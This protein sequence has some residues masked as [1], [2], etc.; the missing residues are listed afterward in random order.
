VAACC[1]IVV[2]MGMLAMLGQFPIAAQA[3]PT[4]TPSGTPSAAIPTE[5]P[6]TTLAATATQ[7][8]TPTTA[9]SATVTET[10][11]PTETPLPTDTAVPTRTSTPPPTP[12]PTITVVIA[13]LVPT[14]T[15]NL[16]SEQEQIGT[17]TVLVF[18]GIVAVIIVFAVRWMVRAGRREPGEG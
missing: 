8:E 11:A 16:T 14:A 18:V 17:I 2:L 13:E 10:P 6:A 15:P 3:D 1:L 7:T 12:T 4:A 9:P 5:T